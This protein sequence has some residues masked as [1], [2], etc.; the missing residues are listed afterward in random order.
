MDSKPEH[1]TAEADAD[2]PAIPAER[3]R[4]G[5]YLLPNLFTTAAMFCGFYAII[6]S[7]QGQY[8]VAAIAVFVAMVLDS[9]DGRVARWTNTQTAFGA[10]YDS[11]S[12]LVSFGL[13]PALTMYQWSLVHL[14][15]MGTAWGK[16]GW[17]AAFIYAAC[18]ALRLARFNTQIGKADKRFFTGMPSPTAAALIVG[19]VWVFH[20]SEVAGRSLQMPALIATVVVGLL[21]VSNFSYYSFKDI[22][23]RGRVPFV[24]MIAVALGFVLITIDPPKVFFTFFVLYGLSGPVLWMTRQVRRY[25]RRKSKTTT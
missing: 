18:A 2:N 12:D 4:K 11:L 10:E 17:L 14:R 22:N 7:I 6:A 20:D 13:A 21:M 23:L 8:E 24:V 16:I 9:L 19:M 1:D 25:Q 15:E 5:I 3:R